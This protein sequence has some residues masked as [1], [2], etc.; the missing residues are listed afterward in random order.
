MV[1]GGVWGRGMGE[2]SGVK[3]RDV[4]WWRCKWKEPGVRGRSAGDGEGGVNGGSEG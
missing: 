1:H 4:G 3:N 2:S